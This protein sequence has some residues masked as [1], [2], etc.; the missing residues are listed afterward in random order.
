MESSLLKVESS[1]A[2]ASGTWNLEG[3]PWKP[4]DT[5]VF[6]GTCKQ[7][8]TPSPG[9]RSLLGNNFGSLY[10]CVFWGWIIPQIFG[11]NWTLYHLHTHPLYSSRLI[12][13][14][15]NLADLKHPGSTKRW[16]MGTKEPYFFF[17]KKKTPK[18]ASKKKWLKICLK[19]RD[20]HRITHR[21]QVNSIHL[22]E[23]MIEILKIFRPCMC[24]N[25]KFPGKTF[26]TF[27]SSWLVHLLFVGKCM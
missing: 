22:F 19:E 26:P 18:G 1:S 7:I 3:S 27:P 10:L 2:N 21:T 16:R 5:W 8:Y 17:G 24:L 14:R 6:I 15:S 25:W 11:L 9:T 20:G 12:A 13:R 23:E 4:H